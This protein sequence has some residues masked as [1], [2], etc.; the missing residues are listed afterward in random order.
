MEV[1]DRN[2]R[3]ERLL[4]KA[5]D[6]EL[7]SVR[8]RAGDAAAVATVQD[9]QALREKVGGESGFSMTIACVRASCDVP[10]CFF[11]GHVGVSLVL[12]SACSH[13]SSLLLVYEHGEAG[14][15]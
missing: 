2:Q 8:A 15:S 1:Q 10:L 11:P 3:V 14:A 6:S 13:S 4:A 9:A 7:Q 5:G 12:F